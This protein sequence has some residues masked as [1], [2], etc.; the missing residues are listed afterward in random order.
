VERPVIRE[1]IP[2]LNGGKSVSP[3]CRDVSWA[4]HPYHSF[5]LLRAEFHTRPASEAEEA[6]AIL[7]ANIRVRAGVER[8]LHDGRNR[9]VKPVKGR[10]IS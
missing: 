3:N 1:I 4:E 6:G 5:T 9:P 2:F 7:A 10:T 8:M